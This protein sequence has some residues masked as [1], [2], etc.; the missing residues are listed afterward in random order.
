MENFRL[1]VFRAVAQHRN[2]RM[3]AEELLLTQPAVTQQIKA[4]EAELGVALFDR[5]GGGIRFTQRVSRRS[6]RDF[7][8]GRLSY[9]EHDG[10]D[11][12]CPIGTPLVAA[13][14]GT[15]VMVRDRWLR[16]GL[17]LA[18]DHGHGVVTQYTHCARAIANLGTVV[19]RGDAI[20]I[21]GAAGLDMVQF[22][23][24]IPPHIHFMVY[25]GGIPVDPFL[26]AGESKRPGIW[27]DPSNPAPSGPRSDDPVA[28]ALSDVDVDA[29]AH[30]TA[31]CTDARI[32]SELAAITSALPPRS[33]I[34]NA[35]VAALLEDALAHDAWAWPDRARIES[36]R[37]PASLARAA[38]IAITL[39]LPKDAYIGIRFADAP[40]T[41]PA[42]PP[43]KAAQRG[44]A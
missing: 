35:C 44:I 42:T 10:T 13:A 34:A 21:S 36:V 20:A 30:A 33:A 4:L 29:I 39:P 27:L 23:P 5:T 17:T 40:W 12:V 9:D 37:P 6:A 2:F 41:I 28:P 15:V 43:A 19:K 11:L 22:F 7:R 1:T 26:A 3:A 24:W 16:G 31:A 32:R 8:G 38:D 18:V 14:P 25:V